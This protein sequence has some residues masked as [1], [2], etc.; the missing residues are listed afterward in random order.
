M[1]PEIEAKMTELE[2]LLKDMDVPAHRRNSIPWLS[3][4]LA[5]RNSHHANFSQATQIVVDLSRMGIR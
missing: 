1:K 3:R 4:N 2:K 5:I